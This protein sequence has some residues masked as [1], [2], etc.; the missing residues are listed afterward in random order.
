[1]ATRRRRNSHRASRAKAKTPAALHPYV[2]RHSLR[3]PY[4]KRPHPGV[5]VTGAWEVPALCDAYDWPTALAGG[6]VIAIVELGGGWVQSD[7]DEFFKRV[8]Q[9]AAKVT[10]VSV[11]GVTNSPGKDLDA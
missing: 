7:L 3:R 2:Q 4:V 10:D 11:G 9:Q 6:G 8:G 1:M 5:R